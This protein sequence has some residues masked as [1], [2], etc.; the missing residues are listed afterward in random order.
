MP[1]HSRAKDSATEYA[2][3]CFSV[4]QSRW[5][6]AE[7]RRVEGSDRKATGPH[8]PQNTA[9]TMYQTTK[10]E[11]LLEDP[12]HSH[13]QSG[14]QPAS[15]KPMCHPSFQL[16]SRRGTILKYSFLERIGAHRVIDKRLA[17]STGKR[18]RP[19]SSSVL[20]MPK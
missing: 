13:T 14:I 12:L 18:S 15:S 5:G 3:M 7:P 1:R 17:V 11:E 20:W 4:V 10:L 19:S 8:V 6:D 16:L 9:C 2:C